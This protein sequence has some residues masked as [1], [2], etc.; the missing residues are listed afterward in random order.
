MKKFK[1]FKKIHIFIFIMIILFVFSIVIPF[2]IQ[3][4]D[5]LSDKLIYENSTCLGCC[6]NES[7]R[8][9]STIQI[10]IFLLA[11]IGFIAIVLGLFPNKNK[12][13]KK[14]NHEK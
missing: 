7:C 1:E 4:I 3:P 14:S 2:M 11:I 9:D 5:F 10:I 6:G 8:D 12:K 13:Q